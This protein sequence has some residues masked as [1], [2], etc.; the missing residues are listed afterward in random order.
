MFQVNAPV[1]FNSEDQ[2]SIINPGDYLIGDINGVVCL[3]KGL[4]E[5]AIDLIASQVEAD[6]NMAKD[7]RN[8]ST[9]SD[10]SK[11]HRANVKQPKL[12]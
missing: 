1:R 10:A 4:A 2:D 12:A 7:I 3:P 11:K 5:Q 6:E 9:F 8:G